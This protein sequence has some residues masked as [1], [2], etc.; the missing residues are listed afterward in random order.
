[1]KIKKEMT[2]KQ[3]VVFLIIISYLTRILIS[4]FFVMFPY[5]P[6]DFYAYVG[7]G[8]CMVESKYL[9][10]DCPI[11]VSPGAEK[12][13]TYGPFFST[14]MMI[15]YS[16]FGEYNFFM[17]KLPA[18][19]FD[20]L[21]TLMIFFISRKFFNQKQSFY[22]SL[23]YCFSFI[24]LYNSAVL[25]NDEVISIFFILSGSYFLINKKFLLS[26][27]FYAT[28]LMFKT[29]G[30]IILPAV[31]YYTLKKY[32]FK[33][34]IKYALLICAIYFIFLSPFIYLAGWEKSTY[35]IFGSGDALQQTG[36]AMSFYNIF[37]YVTDVRIDFLLAPLLIL[38]L[39]TTFCLFFLYSLKNREI[40]LFRNFALLWTVA[41]LFS[42]ELSGPYPYLIIPYLLIILGRNFESKELITRR[43]L[44]GL[45]L[46][47]I[48]LLIFSIIYRWGII[49]Y[50]IFD[51][52]LLLTAVI[53]AP[54]GTYNILHNVKKNYKLVWTVIILASIMFEELHAAPLVILPMEKLADKL[55]DTSKMKIVMELYGDHIDSKSKFLAYGIFY[56]GAAVIMWIGLICLIYLILK[57]RMN[58]D[59][60]TL[61]N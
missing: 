21:N 41:L 55:I 16:I 30:L 23:L 34:G 28:S 26:A 46:I 10:I 4:Q 47:L 61:Q 54:L 13:T 60:K 42:G 18:I 1:M 32:G 15:W 25:G 45:S 50:T 24:V 35:Y 33:T 14:L 51:R 7:A 5:I 17:F 22:L 49:Q 56:G 53:L 36:G 44:F 20:V 3:I 6:H 40:E 12:I 37:A 19:V 43:W 29:V 52:V 11:W 8:K 27:V 39:L 38:S 57:D 31:F 58:D 9:M 59:L 48:S 2:E